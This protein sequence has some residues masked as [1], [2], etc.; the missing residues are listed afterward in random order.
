MSTR[1]SL[2]STRPVPPLQVRDVDFVRV[3]HI[4]TYL[5]TGVESR[6]PV[7]S[8]PAMLLTDLSAFPASFTRHAPLTTRHALIASRTV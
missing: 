2:F 4:S 8:A 3:V 6:V 1:T 7:A 5:G